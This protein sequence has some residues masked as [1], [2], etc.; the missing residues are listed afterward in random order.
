LNESSSLS[1]S[2]IIPVYNA[3]D[4]IPNL[5]EAL[6]AQSR[7]A[8]EILLVD[9]GSKDGTVEVARE[10]GD[11]RTDVPLRILQQENSG[12][13]A[14]RNFGAREATGD[15]LFFIDGDCIPETDWLEKMMEPF[16]D[17]R[18]VG[19]QGAYRCKQTEIVARFCQLE[20]EDR[21]LRMNREETIDFIGTYAA[22]Y[23]REVFLENGLFDDRYPMA[24]GEDA[25]FSFRLAGKGLRM[26]FQPEAIVYHRHPTSLFKYLKQKYWRAYWRNLIYRRHR[27]R[28]LKDSYTPNTL[29]FQTLLGVLFPISFAALWLPGP[30]WLVPAGILAVI[31]AFTIPFSLWAAKKDLTVAIFSPVFLLLRTFALAAGAG[32]GLLK[33]LWLNEDYL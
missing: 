10:W 13:A 26:V 11:R 2:V 4:L 17:E 20:I 15:L 7:P 24:S 33:G 32:Y 29:K 16:G 3:Q 6:A 14:A 28:M 22:G 30:G 12:P 5:L 1:A 31:I 9:D 18:L 8:H 27:G 23:R 21:Y 25:D 19:V